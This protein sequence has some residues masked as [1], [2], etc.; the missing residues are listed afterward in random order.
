MCDKVK[1]A[2]KHTRKLKKKKKKPTES[3]TKENTK[4]KLKRKKKKNHF[5]RAK[6]TQ[7]AESMQNRMRHTEYR[8]DKEA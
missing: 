2:A 1:T 6:Y 3:Q 7:S 8:I 4:V 5:E